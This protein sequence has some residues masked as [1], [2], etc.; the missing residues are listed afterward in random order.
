MSTLSQKLRITT[1]KPVVFLT[2]AGISAESQIPTFRGEEGYWMVGSTHYRPTELATREA[3]A[4]LPAEVWGWYIY[5]RTVCRR[6]EPNSG[7]KLLAAF[8]RNLGERFLLVTQNVD[9]LHLRAGNSLKRTYQVH[10]NID[11]MRCWKECCSELFPIPM[12]IGELDR[13]AALTQEQQDL[14]RCP[15]CQGLAR[16]H[17]LWFDECY[18]EEVFRF[19]SSLIAASKC[20]ILISVG[21]SGSTNL[22]TQMVSQA[23]SRGAVVVDINPEGGPY[24]RQAQAAGGFWLAENAG[25]GL[26]KVAEAMGI[27][28]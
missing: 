3:F 6:A 14:L 16:P 25:S 22:P 21:S 11:Y 7:H 9:G 10:G 27:E 8:E 1:N 2:G 24:A 23:C 28:S 15:R 5:R 17:V 12:E 26:Q 13:G 19:H 4:K 18:D 20:G